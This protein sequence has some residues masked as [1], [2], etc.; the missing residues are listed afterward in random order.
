MYFFGLRPKIVAPRLLNGHEVME[1]FNLKPSELIGRLLQT[2]EDARLNGDI[3]TKKEA[4]G[5]V[6]RLL[7]LEGDAGIEPATPSSGGLCSI[8]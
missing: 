8:R 7:E 1:Y 3:E 6:A 4:T 2:V 5:L